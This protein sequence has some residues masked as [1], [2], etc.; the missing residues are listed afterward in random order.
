MMREI[1]GKAGESTTLNNIATVCQAQGD[2]TVALENLEQ[3]LAITQQIGDRIG[4]GTTLNNIAT[5]CEVQR[6]YEAALS[7][8]QQA[9]AIRQQIGDQAGE[10]SQQLSEFAGG[11]AITRQHWP[12]WNRQRRFKSKFDKPGLCTTC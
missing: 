5:V 7:K 3:A 4:E 2:Y 8:H 11:R 1:G 9:L 10:H 6:D 12:I